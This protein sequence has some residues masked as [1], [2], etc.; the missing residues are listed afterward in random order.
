MIRFY[1]V[2]EREKKKAAT[3][4]HS[5]Q[6]EYLTQWKPWTN[7]ILQQA[8]RSGYILYQTSNSSFNPLHS[9]WSKMVFTFPPWRITDC[10]ASH[11]S[12]FRISTADRTFMVID[13]ESRSSPCLFYIF[14]PQLFSARLFNACSPSIHDVLLDLTSYCTWTCR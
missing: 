9:H 11:S 7:V 4:A 13:S 8:W 3:Q 6:T 14:L 10:K 1:S 2:V 5:K 12:W